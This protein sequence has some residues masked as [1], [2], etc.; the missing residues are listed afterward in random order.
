MNGWIFTADGWRHSPRWKRAINNTLRRFQPG[1]MKWVIFTRS[2]GG[3]DSDPD[4]PPRAIGY[5]FGPVRHLP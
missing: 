4:S 1:P 3:D 2:E 5:G